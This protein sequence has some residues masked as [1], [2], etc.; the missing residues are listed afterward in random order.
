[1]LV[2]DRLLVEHNMSS[3]IESYRYS[4]WFTK[5]IDLKMQFTQ[6]ILDFY[7]EEIDYGI[8]YLKEQDYGLYELLYP[9]ILDYQTYGLQHFREEE[10]I[11]EEVKPKTFLEKLKSLF[12]K[13]RV[14][15]V[16]RRD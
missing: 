14:K 7:P 6:F 15:V 12:E 9:I 13:D 8:G 3:L 4:N 16:F 10:P 2:K 11:I 1:M 5:D